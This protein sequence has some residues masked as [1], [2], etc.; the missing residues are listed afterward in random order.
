MDKYGYKFYLEADILPVVETVDLRKEVASVIDL[1]DKGD[2]QP[3]LS[4]FSSIFVSTGTNLNNAHFLASELVMAENTVVGKAVDVEHEEDQIIGHI[5]KCAFTDTSGNMLDT[6]KLRKM[7]IA[8]LDDQDMNIEIASVVYKTRFP[9]VA[10]EIIN[11]KWKVSMEVYYKDY[12]ILVGN[13]I[14]TKDEAIACGFDVSKEENYGKVAKLVMADKVVA[15]GKV[16]RVLRGLCFSG[17]GIVKN[18]AN[19]PSVVLEAVATKDDK[20]VS[21]KEVVIENDSKNNN[22]TII[23]TEDEKNLHSDKQSKSELQ[24]NDTVGICVNYHKEILD[25][26]TKDPDSK[27]FGE[28]VC[29]KFDATCPTYGNATDVA[30]LRNVITASVESIVNDFCKKYAIE[31]LT[32]NLYYVLNKNKR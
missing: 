4:Y 6:A 27:V 5:Y 15:E 22:V 29:T 2:R 13:T 10:K 31:E 16:V 25:S 8:S 9:E 23:N 32:D 24:Y 11:K 14:L 1:P 19:P 12:D 28:H 17:V 18:P 21:K 3:D 20:I 7:E 26:Q 30:C